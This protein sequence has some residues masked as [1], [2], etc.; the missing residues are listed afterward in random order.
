MA[1]ELVVDE[2][3]PGLFPSLSAVCRHRRLEELR[4]SVVC[5][6]EVMGYGKEADMET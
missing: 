1:R 2:R 3:L 6:W 5:H 4:G